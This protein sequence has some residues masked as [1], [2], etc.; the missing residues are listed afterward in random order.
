MRVQ[1]GCIRIDK[2]SD[3]AREKLQYL[4]TW[5]LIDQ[6]YR[7]DGWVCFIAHPKYEELHEDKM[8][9]MQK[10]CNRLSRQFLVEYLFYNKRGLSSI[11]A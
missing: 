9:A 6:F 10:K 1:N 11:R 2:L 3:S 7:D 4:Y 5:K 8:P